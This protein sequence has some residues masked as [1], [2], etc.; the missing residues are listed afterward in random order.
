MEINIKNKLITIILIIIILLV[1][2][3]VSRMSPDYYTVPRLVVL[4][5]CSAILFVLVLLNYKKIDV[6][7]KDIIILI[8]ALLA[9]ISTM[10]SNSFKTSI[11]GEE[12]R[13][14]GLI[15]IYSYIIIYISAKKFFVLKNNKT[16]LNIVYLVYFLIGVLGI[17]QYYIK[18][19]QDSF[20]ELLKHGESAGTFGNVNFFGS[21]IC[22]GLPAFIML[23]ITKN[24]KLS[25]VLSIILFFNLLTCKTRSAWLAMAIIL[26]TIFIYIIAK[27][28]KKYFLRLFILLICFA[29]IFTYLY[30]PRKTVKS[31]G[32]TKVT[33]TQVNY[34]VQKT[35]EEINILKKNGINKEM[36]SHRL[37]IWKISVD[38]IKKHPLFGVG[39]DN[40]ALG[41][42]ENEPEAISE[43]MED[44]KTYIS[45]AHNEY[46]QI[47]A[48][49]GIPALICYLTFLFMIVLDNKKKILNNQNS[50][51]LFISTSC[52]L[53]QA[54]FNIST[55]GI[56]P[57][58][59]I[60]LGLMDNKHIVNS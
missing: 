11:F 33:T 41:I 47:A 43:Y 31:N 2:T 42:F 16:L 23:Y 60:A 55:V 1:P 18:V 14:E 27:K 25:F 28:D 6:D 38:L 10:L 57:L 35:S 32:E 30:M 56:A 20:I 3:V 52:Y 19:P 5:V 53:I 21:F 59:W 46:L 8:F 9:F 29:G 39:V 37:R 12:G 40:L 7:K 24:Y 34:K 26:I 51:I 17:L 13:R 4:L 15:T 54:F 49:I 22:L 44:T 48:T 50:F 36:G 45:K 58:F